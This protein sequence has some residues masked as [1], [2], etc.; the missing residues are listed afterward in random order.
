M[1]ANG[2]DIKIRRIIIYAKTTA[3]SYR[4]IRAQ[5]KLREYVEMKDKFYTASLSSVDKN[6]QSSQSNCTDV[7]RGALLPPFFWSALQVWD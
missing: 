2:V 6:K 3:V 1:R 7:L 4:Q 5:T